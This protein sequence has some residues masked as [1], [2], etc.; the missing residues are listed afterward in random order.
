MYQKMINMLIFMMPILMM[1]GCSSMNTEFDCPMKPGVRCESI[2]KVNAKVDSGLIHSDESMS[3]LQDNVMFADGEELSCS[4]TPCGKKMNIWIAP[5]TD[6]QGN[7][8][9][10]SNVYASTDNKSLSEV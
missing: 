1:A 5:F 8:H 7:Y 4:D 10:A 6:N 2:D 9:T 3:C